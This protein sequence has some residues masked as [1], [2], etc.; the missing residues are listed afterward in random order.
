MK[1]RPST[2]ARAAP[3][4]RDPYEAAAALRAALRLFDRRS[5]EIT[6]R[7]HLT[8]RGYELLLMVKTG[9]EAPGA[10]TPDE[11]ESRL[12]L[13]KSTVAEL[14]QR[15]E[16]RGLIVR[17]LHPNRRGAIVIALTPEGARRLEAAFAELGSE[18]DRLADALQ[19]RLSG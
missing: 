3:S 6:R 1:V 4:E 18:R 12:Q 16:A 10:A 5:E 19:L 2:E 15:N 13:A 9:R 14:I 7:H 17:A 8:A 11:L